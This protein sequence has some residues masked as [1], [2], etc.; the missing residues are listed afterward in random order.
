MLLN[1]L[2]PLG[3]AAALVVL[4]LL[5][6]R[7]NDNTGSAKP[8]YRWFYVAAALLVISA[9]ARLVGDLGG[10]TEPHT[11][12]EWVLLYD[13]LPALGITLGLYVAWRYW[14]WLLA[15]RD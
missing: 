1:A 3:I 9:A 8:Y 2:A 12:I 15:E 14:S 6:K 7:M 13:G 10:E 5:S 4:G 11:R